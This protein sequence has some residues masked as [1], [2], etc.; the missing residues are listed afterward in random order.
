M[1]RTTRAA[2]LAGAIGTA[3]ITGIALLLGLSTVTSLVSGLVAGALCAGLVE[4]SAL[5]AGTADDDPPRRADPTDRHDD[6][7]HHE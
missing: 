4:A 2:L 5:R 6:G 3:S 1:T 7:N